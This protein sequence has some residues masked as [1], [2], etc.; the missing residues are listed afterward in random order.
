MQITITH[1]TDTELVLNIHADTDTLKD[2]KVKAL[3]NLSKDMK[4]AGFRPGKAPQSVVEKSV[5]QPLLQEEFLNLVINEAYFMAVQTE[6]LHVT[7]QPKVEV[8]KFVP[9]DTVE[10]KA[11]VEC[12][13]IKKLVDY[14]KLSTK[15]V[16]RPIDK[17]RIAEV[18]ENMRTQLAV[19][20]DIEREAQMGDQVWIDFHGKD[21]KGKDVKGAQGTNY[22]LLLGSNTFIPGFEEHVVGLS[23][24]QSKNFTITFPKDYGVKAL[25]AKKVTFDVSVVKVQSVEKPAL[26]SDFFTKISPQISSKI[27]LEKDIEKQLMIEADSAAERDF[28]NAL[29]AEIIAKSE[30]IIPENLIDEQCDIVLRDLQQN[31]LYR[32]QTMQEYLESVSMSAEEQKEKEARPEALRRLQAGILLNEI[33]ENERVEVSREELDSR[34]NLLKQRYASDSEMLKQLESPTNRREIATQ[35]LTEKTISL[36]KSYNVRKS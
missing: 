15:K 31:L 33:A 18:I 24:G 22:P 21:T 26:D 35:V 7:S 5:S 10:F 27:E 14:K 17:T 23:T 4:I 20:K 29:V 28:E 36:I 34:L 1:N 30:I 11:T 6:K 13:T 32:G 3:K 25:Q 8:V 9:F 2:S 19:K 16:Q 12:I